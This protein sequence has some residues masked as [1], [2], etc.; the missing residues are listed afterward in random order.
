[1]ATI[2]IS[3]PK[4]LKKEM[5]EFPEMNWTGIIRRAFIDKIKELNR[6]EEKKNGEKK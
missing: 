6:L 4:E 1:M 5:E 3:I 2:T